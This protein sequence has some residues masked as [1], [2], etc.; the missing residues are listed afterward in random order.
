G[1]NE[2]FFC[3]TDRL[4]HSSRLLYGLLGNRLRPVGLILHSVSQIFGPI[5]LRLHLF[6]ELLRPSGLL[7]SSTGK[8]LSVLATRA[9]FQPL[10]TDKNGSESGHNN[11]RSSPSQRSFFKAGHLLFYACE[12][13]CGCWFCW[14]GVYW[15]G[16]LRKRWYWGIGLIGFGLLLCV[17][18]G[19]SLLIN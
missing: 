12:L 13:L 1:Q 4:A 5:G 11:S 17:H 14:R 8:L 3:E 16:F 15:L 2:L 9:H 7:R 19:V 18:G 6:R 10:K